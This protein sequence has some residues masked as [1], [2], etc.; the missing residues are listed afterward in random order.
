[1]YI[2]VGDAQLFTAAFG[3]AQGRPLLA[4]GGWIGSWELWIEP[5]AFLSER[6]RTLAFDH[7]GAG[8]TLAPAASITFD[9]LVEDVFAVLDA[10]QVESAVLAGESFGAAV[11]LEAA[12]RRPARVTGLVLAGSFSPRGAALPE[13][14]PFLMGLQHH[15]EPTLEGFVRACTPEGDLAIRAWGRHI[16]NRASQEAAIALYRLTDRLEL[17]GPLS[18]IRQPTLLIHGEADVI[19]PLAYAR[20]LAEGLPQARLVVLPGV[21]HVPTLTRPAEVAAAIEAFFA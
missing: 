8:A 11:A 21:G 1:M 14:D 19:A 3:P 2:T 12:R 13:A 5:F 17:G 6:W 7:R 4:V 20:A 16:L 18:E 15:Y 9:R 10:Y